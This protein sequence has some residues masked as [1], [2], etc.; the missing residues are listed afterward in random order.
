MADQMNLCKCGMQKKPIYHKK[1]DAYFCEDCDQW[2]ED[3]CEDADCQF[4]P[5]RPNRPS[6]ADYD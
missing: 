5:T 4:C 2:L 1:H 6:E 3:A